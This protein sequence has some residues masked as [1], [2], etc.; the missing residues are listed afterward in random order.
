MTAVA[1][2]GVR[3]HLPLW[4]KKRAEM[5]SRRSWGSG[6]AREKKASA[7]SELR[8]S[9]LVLRKSTGDKLEGLPDVSLSSS[10]SSSLSERG[11]EREGGRV[12]G[13]GEEGERERG[14]GREGEGKRGRGRERGK[15]RE[16]VCV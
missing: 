6:E 8:L 13:R 5:L 2:L 4:V 3:P 7:W 12:R 14:R 9:K 10:S 16:G 11:R 15:G 1:S